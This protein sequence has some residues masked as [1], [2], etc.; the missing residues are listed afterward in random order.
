MR[1]AE[2]IEKTFELHELPLTLTDDNPKKWIRVLGVLWFV[3][4]FIPCMIL[5]I[6]VCGILGIPAMIQD[7]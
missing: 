2:I 6:I 3:V 7:A 5:T 1:I 4:W